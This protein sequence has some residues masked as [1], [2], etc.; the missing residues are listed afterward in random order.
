MIVPSLTPTV[1][2]ETLKR[3]VSVTEIETV[4]P[5]VQTV[6]APFLV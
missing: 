2:R 5:V 4:S 6:S 1:V 3:S